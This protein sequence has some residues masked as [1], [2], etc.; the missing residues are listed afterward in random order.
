LVSVALVARASSVLFF[1]V[2][3]SKALASR[4]LPV[5]QDWAAFFFACVGDVCSGACVCVL[6][7]P[8]LNASL[9]IVVCDSLASPACA[10][11][12]PRPSLPRGLRGARCVVDQDLC[13]RVC[14]NPAVHGALES[15]SVASAQ[16][17][18]SR[19]A[20]T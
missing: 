8:R 2:S 19:D 12:I 17:R 5:A 10:A 3:K 6:C 1:C 7:F 20:S 18:T 9:L 14:T 13:V 4:S 15:L 16:S 11:G